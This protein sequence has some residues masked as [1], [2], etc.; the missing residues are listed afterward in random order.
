MFLWCTDFLIAKVFKLKKINANKSIG[1]IKTT[2]KD[3][4][5]SKNWS[6]QVC[7]G[8]KIDAIVIDYIWD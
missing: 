3:H 7:N 6:Y 5:G 2:Q 4:L 8:Y 1:I